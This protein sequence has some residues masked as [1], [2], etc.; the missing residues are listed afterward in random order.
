MRLDSV[1]FHTP[2][3]DS[4]FIFFRRESIGVI[5]DGYRFEELKEYPLNLID[6]A[7]QK[8]REAFEAVVNTDSEAEKKKAKPAPTPAKEPVED[9]TQESKTRKKIKRKVVIVDKRMHSAQSKKK[10]KKHDSK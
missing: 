2:D 10:K 9:V 7:I 5:E 8:H 4:H 1:S 6:A 3:S